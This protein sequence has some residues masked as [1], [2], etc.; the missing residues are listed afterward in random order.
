MKGKIIPII[1]V[2]IVAL[3]YTIWNLIDENYYYSLFGL[4]IMGAQLYQLKT[5]KK[6]K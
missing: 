2:T 1:V 4:F 5:I 3:I 6:K